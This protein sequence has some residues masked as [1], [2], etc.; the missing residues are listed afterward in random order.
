MK[1]GRKVVYLHFLRLEKKTI[2]RLTYKNPYPFLVVP[3]VVCLYFCVFSSVSAYF[4]YKRAGTY[5]SKQKDPFIYSDLFYFIKTLPSSVLGSSGDRKFLEFLFWKIP[6]IVGLSWK[7]DWTYVE[8]IWYCR[9]ALR[10]SP[11]RISLVI[12]CWSYCNTPF[13]LRG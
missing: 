3:G 4:G 9:M 1:W 2:S 8:S 12:I 11:T 5:C 6:R 7:L 13:F 10:L